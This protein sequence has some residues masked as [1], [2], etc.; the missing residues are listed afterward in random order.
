MDQPPLGHKEPRP[1]RGRLLWCPACSGLLESPTPLTSRYVTF[2]R[3]NIQISYVKYILYLLP[4]SRHVLEECM[5]I[6]ACRICEG[7]RCF[8]TRC[9][10]VGLSQETAYK[11]FLNGARPDGTRIPKCEHLQRGASLIRLT[12]SW[13]NTWEWSKTVQYCISLCTNYTLYSIFVFTSNQEL[14][15]LIYPKIC[16]YI[17]T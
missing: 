4:I 14:P 2:S 6:E 11:L 15:S 1:G 8:F 3:S 12:E 9:C 16:I 7:V 17:F 10:V 13:L 5:A